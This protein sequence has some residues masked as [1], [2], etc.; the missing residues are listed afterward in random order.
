MDRHE[1]I[2][3]T[4]AAEV[5]CSTETLSWLAILL[6]LNQYPALPVSAP[7]LDVAHTKSSPLKVTTMTR[8]IKL[9]LIVEIP[10]RD[11]R[12]PFTPDLAYPTV[13]TFL[14]FI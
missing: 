11:L 1:V 6:L 7:K 12:I 3:G 13:A 8:F 2:D 9:A 4:C 5:D 14:F 10:F